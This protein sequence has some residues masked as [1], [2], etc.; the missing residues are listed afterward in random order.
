MSEAKIPVL[1]LF[2]P[3]FVHEVASKIKDYGALFRK[4]L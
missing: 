3:G 1:Y 4:K 2:K